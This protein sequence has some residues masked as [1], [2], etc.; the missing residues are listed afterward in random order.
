[1]EDKSA[2]IIA[3]VVSFL[4][5]SWIVMGLRCYVRLTLS[6]G[7][8]DDLFAIASM[9]TF[10]GFS[11]VI[12]YGATQGLGK[13]INDLETPQEI[14]NLYKSFYV[15]DLLYIVS[16]GLVK[17]SFCLSLLRVVAGRAY[18]YAIY[19]VQIVIIII[20]TF[21]FFI[22]LLT[23]LPV[24]LYWNLLVDPSRR[25]KCLKYPEL[26]GASYSHG[27]I[28]FLADVALAIIPALFLRTLNL[29]YRAKLSVGLLLGFGSIA[30]VATIARLP[31][32]D[33][34]Y[35]P[36]DERNTNSELIM[37]S[38]V[39]IGISIIAI[40]AVTLK[41][42]M[43]K[44][45][46]FFSSRNTNNIYSPS[47]QGRIYGTNVGNFSY[48]VGSGVRT[49]RTHRLQK[50]KSMSKRSGS[51]RPTARSSSEEDIWGLGLKGGGHSI[52]NIDENQDDVELIPTGAIQKVV[53]FTTSDTR[54][55]NQGPISI[56][57]RAYEKREPG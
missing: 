39:E 21:Y 49:T 57:E 26:A 44:Y 24:D 16:S 11:A 25:G 3:V 31:Y 42:L 54:A 23:C 9:L 17:M 52:S 51:A 22:K 2:A 38:V 8:L 34:T 32:I 56:P 12:L 55:Q 27:G 50:S 1:M 19:A 10:S 48:E 29:S 45:H 14:V 6:R 7:G 33:R 40:S 30:S 47:E 13:H 43:V 36:I 18:V 35:D 28:I 41:P 4:A 15:A 5:A 37:W 53:E 46:L 20:T